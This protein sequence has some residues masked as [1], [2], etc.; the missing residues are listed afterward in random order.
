MGHLSRDYFSRKMGFVIENHIFQ[1][2]ERARRYMMRICCMSAE[3]STTYLNRLR[4]A[5]MSRI[6]AAKNSM[7]EKKNASTVACSV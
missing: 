2:E 3:E 4:K 7:E 6:R 1:D 5:Y